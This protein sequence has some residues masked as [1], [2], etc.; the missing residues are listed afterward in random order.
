MIL[1]HLTTQS[2][3]VSIRQNGIHAS[4]RVVSIGITNPYLTIL[5]P[6]FNRYR[7]RWSKVF[8]TS[9]IPKVLFSQIG[10]KWQ[11]GN[12]WVIE[13]VGAKVEPHQYHDMGTYTLSDFEYVCEYVNPKQLNLAYPIEQWL[14]ANGCLP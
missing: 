11:E 13:V 12:W 1:Y 8:L 5:H 7:N 4:D 10:E 6:W 9:D 2:S 14:R 3:L